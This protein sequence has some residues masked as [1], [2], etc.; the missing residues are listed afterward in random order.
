[1]REEREVR[2]QN[3]DCQHTE[4]GKNPER[5]LSVTSSRNQP[6]R[7]ETGQPRGG[8]SP[9][10]KVGEDEERED[11]ACQPHHHPARAFGLSVESAPDE[12]A[13]DEEERKRN[14]RHVAAQE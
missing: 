11:R 8:G 2:Q 6:E 12:R 5:S 7:G 3:G 13:E 10:I 1:M 14:G 4:H 9:E